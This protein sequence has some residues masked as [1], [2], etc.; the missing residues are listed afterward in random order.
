MK[1]ASRRF[2]WK[3]GVPSPPS[4]R[5]SMRIMTVVQT[6]PSTTART[7]LHL[8]CPI[9]RLTRSGRHVNFVDI[10]SLAAISAKC[11]GL[12]RRQLRSSGRCTAMRRAA[13]V[14]VTLRVRGT[15]QTLHYRP[16]QHLQKIA[17]KA[18]R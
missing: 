10:P 7:E 17:R 3:A 1:L 2:I 6:S 12:A 8:F 18:A 16:E 4:C 5:H 14:L 9:R 13:K 11:G 15:L